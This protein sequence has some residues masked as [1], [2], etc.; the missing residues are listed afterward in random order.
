MI[1]YLIRPS[2]G[3]RKEKM[4]KMFRIFRSSF[5]VFGRR[6]VM[7]ILIFFSNRVRTYEQTEISLE[8]WPWKCYRRI[9]IQILAKKSV[10]EKSVKRSI[11]MQILVVARF[12]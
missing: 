1:D 11:W 12:H 3:Q 6:Q 2:S 8:M 4:D 7:L 10:G 9:L 5:C